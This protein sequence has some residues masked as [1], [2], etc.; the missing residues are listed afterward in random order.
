MSTHVRSSI[1]VILMLSSCI[2]Y[3]YHEAANFKCV[4][5]GQI[6]INLAASWYEPKIS[7]DLEVN[8]AAE[9]AFQFHLGWFAEPILLTGDYP[10]VMKQ[11]IA[12]TSMS[13][14]VSHRLPTFTNNESQIVKGNLLN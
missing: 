9:R 3:L 2:D 10:Q 6:G 14:E 5:P 13:E 11:Y 4:S 7:T 12:N 1:F 8:E